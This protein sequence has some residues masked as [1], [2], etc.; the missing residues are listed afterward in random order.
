MLFPFLFLRI[1]N[2]RKKEEGNENRE[3]K[4]KGGK[5]KRKIKRSKNTR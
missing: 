5:K 3:K 4:E 2:A 1:A